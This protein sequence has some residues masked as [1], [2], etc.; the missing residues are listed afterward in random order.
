MEK[1]ERTI[2][3]ADIKVNESLSE[4]IA[5]RPLYMGFEQLE[6]ANYAG[7]TSIMYWM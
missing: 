6:E 7:G 5:E 3:E 1:L 4:E 2:K